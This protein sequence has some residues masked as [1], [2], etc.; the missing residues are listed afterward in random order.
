M[1]CPRCGKAIP[2]N[3]AFCMHCGASMA[4]F[5]MTP[6][7][8]TTAGTSASPALAQSLDSQSRRNS[9][10]ATAVIA[11]AAL[12]AVVF[13]TRAA[14][15]WGTE[16]SRPDGRTLQ[17]SGSRPDGSILQA[18]GS[19]PS[20]ILMAPGNRPAPILAA[21]AKAPDKMPVD[22]YNWLKHL[23]KCEAQ[24]VALAGDQSAEVTVWMQKNSVLG[25][26]MGMMDPYDQ[27][28]PEG[29]N[30]KD[31]GTYTKG[32]ILDLRPKWTA[33]Y[34]F[35]RSYPP[36]AEC[37]PIADDF[38][39]AIV[40]VPGMMGDLGDILNGTSGSPDDALKKLKKMQN[41]SYGDIDRY[42]IR[43]DG[44]LGDI[45]G[46][47]HMNKWFNVKGDV[48]AGGIMGKL[49]FGGG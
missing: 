8:A 39:K 25:A 20:G 13:G 34:Q 4:S 24:K 35:F 44:K 1:N 14:G 36:P 46:K 31:P 42:F 2:A 17:A 48:M 16:S 21:D 3:T 49:P 18:R 41:S 19:S 5:N 47:Y 7:T 12:L 6:S 33:L 32:K 23:E 45:C 29:D 30:D 43:C 9:L 27:S 10:I 37:K 38:D 22:V 11:F 40:E 15:V 28:G 26:G